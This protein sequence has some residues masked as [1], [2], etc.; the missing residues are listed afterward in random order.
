[1]V[2]NVLS[3]VETIVRALHL[4]LGRRE[5]LVLAVVTNFVE[6]GSDSV[7]K[8]TCQVSACDLGHVRILCI[9]TASIGIPPECLVYL[10]RS[11]LRAEDGKAKGG[12]R[13]VTQSIVAIVGIIACVGGSTKTAETSVRSC[14]DGDGDETTN[15][16]QVENDKQPAKELRS[17]ALEAEVDDQS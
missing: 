1:M 7:E 5:A 8:T 2:V 14:S 16:E 10:I 11:N 13:Q 17:A 4:F 9:M 15:E 12:K 3:V 6:D